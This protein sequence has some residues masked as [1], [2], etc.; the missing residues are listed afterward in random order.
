MIPVSNNTTISTGPGASTGQSARLREADVYTPSTSTPASNTVQSEASA[1]VSLS[2]QAQAQLAQ[3][4]AQA[5]AQAQ[6]QIQNQAPTPTSTST[7]TSTPAAAA[8]ATPTTVTAQST[9]F[10][11][12]NASAAVTDTEKFPAPVSLVP[13]LVYAEA[14][15][16]LNGV[17]S[18]AERRA[19]DVLHPTLGQRPTD[20]P[21]KRV[22]DAELREYTAIANKQF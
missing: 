21:P 19:Y 1:V 17:I 4:P 5:Q 13:N 9:S 14:D 2:P 8:A 6:T 10:Q 22:V 12:S 18:P 11:P 16:D 15:S 7:P 20:V 3:A